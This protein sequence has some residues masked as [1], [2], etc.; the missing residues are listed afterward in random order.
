MVASVAMRG[1]TRAEK[2]QALMKALS[3][4]A[5][6]PGA[7]YFTG[8]ASAVLEGWRESTIDVDLK[9]DPEA[10]GVFEALPRLKDEL[11]LNVELASPDDFIPAL[12]DWKNRSPLI[13]QKGPLR[14]YHYDFFAQALSKIERGHSQD[15]LDVDEMF[16]RRLVNSAELRSLFE[17]I[18]PGLNRFPAIDADDFANKVAEALKSHEGG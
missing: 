11:D 10:P 4:A 15:V 18:R 12:P 1:E 16:R 2:I 8:G 17:R 13:A 3:R 14:F 5:K 9:L 7:I 6:G